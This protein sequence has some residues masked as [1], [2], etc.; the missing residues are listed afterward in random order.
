MS[1]IDNWIEKKLT[2]IGAKLGMLP[3]QWGSVPLAQAGGHLFMDNPA[4]QLTGQQMYKTMSWVNA[5][6]SLTA[7]IAAPTKLEVEHE[8]D[9]GKESEAI[10]NHP[11]EK[12]LKRPNPLMS[13]KEFLTATYSY[14]GLAGNAYWWLNASN[15]TAEPAELW[16]INP[17][18]IVPMPDDKLFIKFYQYTAPNGQLLELP[19]DQIVHFKRFNPE[20]PFIGLSA[21]DTLVNQANA[22]MGRVRNDAKIYTQGNGV[23]PGILAFADNFQPAEWDKMK[24]DFD[25]GAKS[26]RRFLM[27]RNVKQGGVQWLQNQL[28]NRDQQVLESRQFTREEIFTVLAPGLASML[29]INATEANSKT[30]KATLMEFVIY[31]MLCDIAEKI[32]TDLMPRYGEGLEAEFEEVRVKDKVLEMQEQDKY[33]Q[34]HTVSEIRKKYYGDKP[35][36]DERDILLPAQVKPDSGTPAPEA[37]PATAPIPPTQ[38][39]NQPAPMDQGAEGYG[40]NGYEDGSAMQAEIKRWKRVARKAMEKGQPMREFVTNI[41]PADV[42]E[43]IKARLSSCKTVEDIDAAFVVERVDPMMM[44][45][46]E[47]KRANDLLAV[48]A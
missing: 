22:D 47:M 35:L 3:A 4:A 11:F 6:I 15:E 24:I 29:A 27:L 21:V 23:P 26:M 9:T 37:Q 30:G 28:S 12:L 46:I 2:G 7:N 39:D 18:D 48:A 32:T 19:I 34:T 38:P 43:Q 17:A 41:I 25:E 5:A 8:G 13:R 45:A 42:Q 20:N 10:A 1:F 40:A 14:Y 16:I 44:I 33:A 36:G 31:P